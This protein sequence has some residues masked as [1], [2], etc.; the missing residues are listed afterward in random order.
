MKIVKIKRFIFSAVLVASNLLY[1]PFSDTMNYSLLL[2]E[3]SPWGVN[4]YTGASLQDSCKVDS[5][6]AMSIVNNQGK[7]G[8]FVGKTSRFLLCPSLD[9]G[10]KYWN[11]IAVVNNLNPCYTE[12]FSPL[13]GKKIVDNCKGITAMLA[14]GSGWARAASSFKVDP[15]THKLQ[16]AL[17]QKYGYVTDDKKSSYKTLY[18]TINSQLTFLSSLKDRVDSLEPG[19]GFYS[20]PYL[21][22][23]A[24]YNGTDSVTTNELNKLS[25]ELFGKGV[26][27][28]AYFPESTFTM[29]LDLTVG[30]QS[31]GVSRTVFWS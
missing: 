18:D 26:D 3:K 24:L 9:F 17:E 10:V 6:K 13:S 11:P 21:K 1:A 25:E 15:T 29:S 7:S 8:L 28:S 30:S 23:C 19:E 31:D 4:A 16:S 22:F 5:L 2:S 14:D 12:K 20:V 27:V